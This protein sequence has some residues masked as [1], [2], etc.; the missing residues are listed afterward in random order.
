MQ[1][2][3]LLTLFCRIISNSQNHVAQNC[4]SDPEAGFFRSKE[5]ETGQVEYEQA[6]GTPGSQTNERIAKRVF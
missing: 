3:S 6:L 2:R 1:E 5:K 4:L